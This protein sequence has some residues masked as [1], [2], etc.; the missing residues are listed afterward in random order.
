MPN[1]IILFN[2]N[3]PGDYIFTR[4]FLFLQ[5]TGF[6][7]AIF[8]GLY[9]WDGKKSDE[10]EPISWFPGAYDLKIVDLNEDYENITHLRPYLC[11]YTNTGKGYSVSANPEK[12]AK[13]ICIDF[14]L[15]IEKVLWVERLNPQEDRFEVVTFRKKGQVGAHDFYAIEKRKPMQGELGLIVKEL[16]QKKS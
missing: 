9:S 1:L 7:M 2:I 11:I 8:K 6:S 15:D 5:V 16:K 10:H 3:R 14:N 4:L 12:F 13:K